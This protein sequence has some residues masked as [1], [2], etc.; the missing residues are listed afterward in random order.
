MYSLNVTEY[1][2]NE[3][4]RFFLLV[5]V[6][7]DPLPTTEETTLT[8]NGQPVV[9]TPDFHYTYNSI[10]IDRVTASNAGEYTF[11]STTLGGT[12]NPLSF[13]LIIREL[14]S[15]ESFHLS[16]NSE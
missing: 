3:G 15:E 8:F 5:D 13:A 16:G 12:S 2:L 1:T 7:G 4:E 11:T 6:F 10:T 9:S 14:Q